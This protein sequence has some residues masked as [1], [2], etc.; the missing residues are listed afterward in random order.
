M[1]KGLYLKEGRPQWEAFGVAVGLGEGYPQALSLASLP[2]R[3]Y[4]TRALYAVCGQATFH[5]CSG[6]TMETPTAGN[7]I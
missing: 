6:F 3:I 4:L 1:E 5:H 7:V 2:P